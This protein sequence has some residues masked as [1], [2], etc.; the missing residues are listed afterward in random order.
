MNVV[1]ADST[2]AGGHRLGA[3]EFSTGFGD[4]LSGTVESLSRIRHIEPS[5]AGVI[6][7]TYRASTTT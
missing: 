2:D 3:L 1:N 4:R 7:L 5:N 6:R